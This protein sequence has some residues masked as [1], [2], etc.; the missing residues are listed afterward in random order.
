MSHKYDTKVNGMKCPLD[1][2][3][4]CILLYL[5]TR[6]LKRALLLFKHV[7]QLFLNNTN[8]LT[9]FTIFLS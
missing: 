5:S 1:S 8:C 7:L 4:E 3:A 9:G 6:L 2:W